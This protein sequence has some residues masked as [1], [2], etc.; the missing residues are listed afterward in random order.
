MLRLVEELG[1]PSSRDAEWEFFQGSLLS[2]A[3]SD[4]YIQASS[5]DI[6][7]PSKVEAAIDQLTIISE[8]LLAESCETLIFDDFEENFGNWIDGGS[9]ATRIASSDLASSGFVSVRLR[10]NTNSSVITSGPHDLSDV[11][12]IRV[13]FHFVAVSFENNEDFW[14]QISSDGSSFTIEEDWIHQVDFENNEPRFETFTIDGPFPPTTYFRFRADATSN[15]DQVYLDDVMIETCDEGNRA[16]PTFTAFAIQPSCTDGE[17]NND[18]SL[19]IF[20]ASSSATHYNFSI[21]QSYSGSTDI[22]EAI[23]F[24][25]F[26]DLPLVL[27]DDLSNPIVTQAYTI[28]VFDAVAGTFHDETVQLLEQD[29]SLDCN[30]QEFIYINE[31]GI[32][33]VLKYEVDAV[34]GQ[35]TE[36]TNSLGETPWYPGNATSQTPSPHGL[37]FDQRGGL[38]IGSEA[39][40][41]APIRRFSCDGTILPTEPNTIFNASTLTNMFSI[42]NTLY[43][44]RQGGPTAYD[45]CTGEL[46]GNM[47]LDDFEGNGLSNPSGL[48]WGLSHNTTTDMV[49]LTSGGDQYQ[50]VWAFTREELEAGISS[51]VSD[52]VDQLIPINFGTDYNS[53]SVGDTGIPDDVAAL[54]GVVGD[55][56]E[57]IYISGWLEGNSPTSSPGFLIKYSPEGSVLAKSQLTPSVR[58]TRGIVWSEDNNLI[59]VANEFNDNSVD[60]ISAYSSND[61]EYLFPAAPNPNVPQNTAGKAMA[62]VKECCPI[63]NNLVIDTLICGFSPGH[64]L[65]LQEILGCNG[66]GCEGA[67][68]LLD[69][70]IGSEYDVCNNALTLLTTGCSTITYSSDGLGLTD[71]CGAFTVTI[72]ISAKLIEPPVLGPDLSLCNSTDIGTIPIIEPPISPEPISFQWQKSETNCASG[73]EDIVGATSLDFAPESVTI[74]TFYRVV[75]TG[76]VDCLGGNCSD[77]SNCF[78]ILIAEDDICMASNSGPVSVGEPVSLLATSDDG[79]SWSWTGPNGFSSDQQN[80]MLDSAIPGTYTVTTTSINGCLST[81]STEVEVL[82]DEVNI[83]IPDTSFCNGSSI[84]IEPINLGG[85]EIIIQQWEVLS[86]S[87]ASGFELSDLES[88]NLT[89][90]ATNAMPGKIDLRYVATSQNN[91]IDTAE[92]SVFILGVDECIIEAAVD[93]VCSG[94]TLSLD[95][96]ST[97][98]VLP[99][100]GVVPSSDTGQGI[101]IDHEIIGVQIPEGVRVTITLPTWD[102]HF[103]EIL[104]NGNQIIP[105]VQEPE[106]WNDGG[107]Q[108]VRPWLPN[109]NG[110]PRSIITIESDEVRYFSSLTVTS[111]EMTEVFPINW[112]T[113]PQPFVTGTN[114]LHF[115]ILNT[116]GPVSGSWIID[117]RGVNGYTYLW[118]TGDTTAE[119]DVT[120]DVTTT[121]DVV[122]TAP[123]GCVSTCERTIYIGDPAISLS[124]VSIESGE[125]IEVQPVSEVNFGLPFSYQWRLISDGS[126]GLSID[127]TDSMELTIDGSGI[128]DDG[129]ELIEL[130]TTNELGCLDRDTMTVTVQGPIVCEIQLG[131]FNEQQFSWG[132]AVQ[133]QGSDAIET[134]EAQVF[135]AEYQIDASQITNNN[136]FVHT[137]VDNGD[138][139]Y[140]HIFTGTSGIPAFSNLPNFEWIGVNFGGPVSSDGIEVSCELAPTEM[141][142]DL[143][144]NFFNE[145]QFAWG[146]GVQNLD[147][148][149]LGSW[150]AV[151]SNANYE[152][153]ASQVTNNDLFIHTQVDNG[154][155]TYDHIFTGT[156][157]IAAFSNLPNF[158]WVGV[159]FGG[160]VSSD[161]IVFNCDVM[162]IDICSVMGTIETP[163]TSICDGENVIVQP[164][165][166]GNIGPGTI[167]Q[168]SLVSDGSTGLVLANA[169]TAVL[170][171]GANSVVQSGTELVELVVN[172]S[173]GCVAIDTMTVSVGMSVESTIEY[174]GCS[175]DGYGIIVNDVV[176]DELNPTGIENIPSAQGCDSII[177]VNLVF[178]EPVVVEAGMIPFSVCSSTGLI[179][180]AD[181][182]AS[183]TGGSTTGLWTTMGDGSFNLRGVF[184]VSGSASIYQLGPQDIENGEVIL[185]L[186]STDPPGPCEPVADAVL[187]IISDITC[188][189]FPWAGN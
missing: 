117:A 109:V 9:D 141:N 122:V 112:V 114:I 135:N 17:V 126:S 90:D 34:T 182:G 18:G 130:V 148:T 26:T 64:Q 48:Y 30:C 77:T 24:N 120:P 16:P 39:R 105:R 33:A 37:A 36:I 44:T 165:I 168:W 134:W 160:P 43:V 96:T 53:L 155:G 82:D 3:G 71:R 59:Y 184:N 183:I 21:G 12:Q 176:Y 10:D 4:V 79:V 138:G 7:G 65:F 124:D 118:S 187:V 175:G 172:N 128:T 47:C 14:F 52:C 166:S 27:V 8:Q 91:S 29:C 116:A 181:L 61:L 159:D 152:I 123:N 121:Y 80:P 145:Q 68:S 63:N 139:T 143:I 95:A 161:G 119:I 40:V 75:V 185:T 104:L 89:I 177:N 19:R 108:T 42:Q 73:F 106:S 133:N 11:D 146:F 66:F 54:S 170:T 58:R 101:S 35:L 98:N 147:G 97:F 100:F 72:N 46:L 158:E 20:Q 142:C 140:N 107:M 67:W 167:Y 99:D 38:F 154:D 171:L 55:H 173:F 50:G 132:F 88:F 85:V 127:N 57:N 28:R 62:I 188:S 186:T 153:D 81:C 60:C 15:G 144:T 49:Y 111:T 164:I 86:T 174:I 74:T 31:P 115:G 103:D 110:L 2:L 157:G 6:A 1:A 102:D 51:N 136:L 76:N 149:N 70:N 179:N 94:T 113:T 151:I 87:T 180:L 137:Q 22:A 41:G 163:D 129:E 93:T 125:I 23:A 56:D 150:E 156:G 69:G 32:D 189:Q 13:S 169:T 162:P 78:T 131:F 5:Q 92:A 25:P 178:N 83:D 45:L 84:T